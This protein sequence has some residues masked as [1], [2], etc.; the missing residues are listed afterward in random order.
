M[1]KSTIIITIIALLAII[2]AVWGWYRPPVT[3]SKTEYVKVPEIKTVTKV[4]RV[5]VP[6]KEI[7]T[8]EKKEVSA[9][10]HLSEEITN[11]DNKQITATAEI[12]PYEGKTNVIAIFDKQN[13]TT[14]I[15]AKQQQLSFFA[16][17]NKRA[18][19]LRYGYASIG[20]A[21]DSVVGSGMEADVY[22]RWDI[23]RI[24]GVHVGLYGEVTSAG[25][26][27]AMLNVEYR[28]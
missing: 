13:N 16:L 3:L 22:A 19:G 9:K 27:R 1:K 4:K 2:A 17:E 6:V 5:R 14:Q 23:L 8:L 15:D 18:I 21:T 11:D 10:L 24:G 25:D 26:G 12:P 7:I 28:F 20:S